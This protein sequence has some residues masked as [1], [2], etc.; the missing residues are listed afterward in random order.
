MKEDTNSMKTVIITEMNKVIERIDFQLSQLDFSFNKKPIVIGGMAME[1]Y[2]IRASGLDIDLVI[3]N[4]DYSKLS[5]LYPDKR[6]DIYGDL[7]VV[8]EP[9]ELWRSIALLDYEFY[10]SQST[11]YTRFSMISLDRLLAMRVFAME[12]DKYMSDLK[13]MKAHYLK[14]HGNKSY[15][16]EAE[17]HAKSYEKNNGVI[18][19]GNYGEYK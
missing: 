4:V 19:G 16:I 2:G 9:F 17:K 11:E 6:K 18:Y 8:I 10:S 13:L 7:G 1:Y 3:D 14:E 12:V 5:D 15:L